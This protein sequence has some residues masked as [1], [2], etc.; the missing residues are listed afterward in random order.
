MNLTPLEARA[1]DVLRGLVADRAEG[2]PVEAANAALIAADI[3]HARDPASARRVA[4]RL[5]AGLRD[6]GAIVERDG[7]V[8]VAEPPAR[9]EAAPQ[10]RAPLRETPRMTS[11]IVR[12][13]TISTPPAIIAAGD[14]PPSRVAQ[15]AEAL[16]LRA[17]LAPAV[18]P[19]GSGWPA[20]PSFGVREPAF[21][22]AIEL[23]RVL[24]RFDLNRERV[25]RGDWPAH[26]REAAALIEKAI[27]A[28]AIGARDG[29]YWHPDHVSGPPL[30]DGAPVPAFDPAATYAFLR[31]HRVGRV[32]GRV[33]GPAHQ[34][35]YHATAAGWVRAHP[36]RRP[37]EAAA[38]LAAAGVVW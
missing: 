4:R 26:Q 2:V 24:P 22:E 30:P 8:F 33:S 10:P 11:S 14:A 25:P 32:A 5:R 6:K 27:K 9:S 31:E 15:L 23:A 20:P 28:G 1:L 36:R 38:G 7:R 34:V 37:I 12:P 21:L 17:L 18:L 19:A 16:R 29:W 35:A 3:S 13:D